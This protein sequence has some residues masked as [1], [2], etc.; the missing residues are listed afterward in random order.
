M[1]PAFS[2]KL[3]PQNIRDERFEAG[4]IGWGIER[5]RMIDWSGLNVKS[6][7]KNTLRE[8]DRYNSEVTVYG[9]GQQPIELNRKYNVDITKYEL[10]RPKKPNY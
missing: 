3:M 6:V 7:P 2:G 5:D 9:L 1:L 10:G 8:W 4:T